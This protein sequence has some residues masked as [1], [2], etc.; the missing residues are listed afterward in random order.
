MKDTEVSG[1]QSNSVSIFF[2]NLFDEQYAAI[3]RNPSA[4]NVS[5]YQTILHN[6]EEGWLYIGNR[7]FQLT[8]ENR[9]PPR[10]DGYRFHQSS[11]VPSIRTLQSGE[12]LVTWYLAIRDENELL[13]NKNTNTS[14]KEVDDEPNNHSGYENGTNDCVRLIR[15]EIWVMPSTYTRGNPLPKK[16]MFH[17]INS[18]RATLPEPVINR[19]ISSKNFPHLL[20]IYN[21]NKANKQDYLT[22]I[23]KF[24]E[25]TSQS[26]DISCTSMSSSHLSHIRLPKSGS[27]SN[28]LTGNEETN[29]IIENKT[30]STFLP[31]STSPTSPHPKNEPSPQLDNNITT[32]IKFNQIPQILESTNLNNVFI[33][34]PAIST[35]MFAHIYDNPKYQTIQPVIDQQWFPGYSS[36]SLN[37]SQNIYYPGNSIH[38]PKPY[39]VMDQI[40]GH[41]I[42]DYH[43]DYLKT[44]FQHEILNSQDVSIQNLPNNLANGSKLYLNH[45]NNFQIQQLTLQQFQNHQ[46][47]QLHPQ[48]S[49]NQQNIHTNQYSSQIHPYYQFQNNDDNQ[50]ESINENQK[51]IL[52]QPFPKLKS[53]SG[54]IS[55][56]TID[57]ALKKRK[58]DPS[59]TDI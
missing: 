6:P 4:Y 43:P 58:R 55:L 19:P 18:S 3:Y 13:Q 32:E 2:Y 25:Q 34:N 15:K 59:N 37:Q 21:D 42:P 54:I 35:D 23:D 9:R 5:Q 17:Y 14:S 30:T 57:D 27:S 38:Q 33:P 26:T 48:L 29:K 8:R 49:S 22:K 56:N 24:I 45:L 39:A 51:K 7:G 41:I 28:V 11:N 16:V 20:T 12:K 40:S 53:K 47:A 44:K 46:F 10:E 52:K 1:D 50:F 36:S 31:C